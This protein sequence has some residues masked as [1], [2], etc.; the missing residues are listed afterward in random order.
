MCYV[1]Y[2][3]EVIECYLFNL[4]GLFV[5]IMLVMM[6]D[7]CFLVLMLYMECVYCMVMMSWY[8]EGWGDVSLWMWVFCN[9]CCWIG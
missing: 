8:L 4:N 1:D 7:G 2:C 9:V 5:G 6:V 3:G